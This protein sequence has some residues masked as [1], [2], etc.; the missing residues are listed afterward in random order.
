MAE[1]MEKQ[2]LFFEKQRFNQVWIWLIMIGTNGV[3][4][5]GFIK[6]IF[7]K[8]PFGDNPMSDT[9][10]LISTI[11][12]LVFSVLLRIVSL[13]TMILNDGIY[14]RFYPIQQAYR[15]CPWEIIESVAVR[16]YDPIG[17]FGGWGYRV[18]FGNSGKAFNVSGNKGI[19]LVFTD[20]SRL[21]IGTQQAEEVTKV[22]VLLGK[23]T[24]S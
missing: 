21:L 23:T 20:K 7:L 9:A 22:L 2:P 3:F 17:E 4:I 18:G 10:L 19:Q 12:M 16:E 24:L 8:I 6:Q 13:Q 11:L 1:P 5:Y 15:I 14:V